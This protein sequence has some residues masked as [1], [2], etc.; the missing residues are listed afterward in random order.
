M[1]IIKLQ[2]IIWLLSVDRFLYLNCIKI[3]GLQ[4]TGYIAEISIYE[5]AIN[6][7]DISSF[8]NDSLFSDGIPKYSMANALEWNNHK[9]VVS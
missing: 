3:Y 9:D 5:K 2:V 4:F 8:V 7:N 6:E 1:W